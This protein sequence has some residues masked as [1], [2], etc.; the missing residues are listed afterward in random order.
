MSISDR[1][2]R[3]APRDYELDTSFIERPHH[4]DPRR[5]GGP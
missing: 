2:E 5:H 4:T 3:A 1:A